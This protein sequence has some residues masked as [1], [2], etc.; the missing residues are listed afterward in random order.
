MTTTKIYD[1]DLIKIIKPPKGKNERDFGGLSD[2]FGGLDIDGLLFDSLKS[3]SIIEKQGQPISLILTGAPGTGKST[4][5]NELLTSLGISSYV[6][7]DPDEIRRI[8]EENGVIFSEKFMSQVTNIFNKRIV[9]YCLEQKYHIVFDT[10]GRNYSANKDLIDKSREY[11]YNSYFVMVY[12]SRETVMKRIDERNKKLQMTQS[13]RKILNLDVA[14]K[15]YDDFMRPNGTAAM[16]LVK[17]RVYPTNIVLYE[18]ENE[19]RLLYKSKYDVLTNKEE[20]ETVVDYPNFYTV[21]INTNEPHFIEV[22]N[23]GGKKVKRKY[24]LKTK[25]KSQR[26]KLKTKTQ[27][28]L[29][30]R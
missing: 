10:T 20:I 22:L 24:K 9:Y 7:I 27:R 2:V 8:L 5:K 6:D 21:Q 30:M 28:K 29:K 19:P 11:G 15:L 18:N 25:R 26:R 3:T 13:G 12:A 1:K 23:G 16:Y 4:I 17:Y 14:S